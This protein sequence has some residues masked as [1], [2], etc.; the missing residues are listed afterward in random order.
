[1]ENED[2]YAKHK[3]SIEKRIT[4]YVMLYIPFEFP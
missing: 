3:I 4:Q 2:Q 1:M